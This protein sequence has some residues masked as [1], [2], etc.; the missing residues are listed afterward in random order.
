M[1]ENTAADGG[2]AF[3]AIL[4]P[5]RSLGPRGFFV[6]MSAVVAVS[7]VAGVVFLSIGA[8]PVPGFLGLDVLL[9]YV[10]FRINYRAARRYET[11]Q[12][13]DDGLT[14][15]VVDPKGKAKSWTFDPYW[16]RVTVDELETG[17]NRLILSSHGRYLN[18]G[19]F[20]TPDERT[21]FADALRDALMNF[22]GTTI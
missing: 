15:R 16:V 5:H 11:V 21:E 18:V 17:S 3:D 19:S 1:T 22:R 7:F 10:A 20:L 13:G 2:Y 6:L 8:W 9:I 14:V 4:R 12:L